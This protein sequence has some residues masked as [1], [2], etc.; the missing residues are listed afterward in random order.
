MTPQNG[1]LET[2]APADADACW[3]AVLARD[4]SCD[5]R[6]VCAVRTTGIYCRPS[7]P[8]G[9]PRREN[10]V[11]Y[12]L[13]ELAERDGFRA[14]KR[15]HPRDATAE[16]HVET[17]R[18]ACRYIEANLEEPLTLAV[19]GGQVGLSPAHLQ[20]IFKRVAGISPRQYAD[21]CRLGRLKAGLKSRRTVTMAMFEAGYGSSSRLYERAAQQ[22]GMTPATYQRG[23]RGMQIR[24]TLAD[25][26]LGRLLLAA[27]ERGVCAVCIGDAD[28]VLE[29]NLRGEYP[30]A[31][32]ER[33]DSALRPLV[34]DM[35]EHLAGERPHLE[36][37][38][39]VQATAFQW[40]VW[41]ELQAI[42]YGETRTYQEVARALGQPSA[43]RAVARAC[44]TNP[45]AVV[46][47]CH[48]VLRTDGGLGGYRWGLQRKQKLLEQE[49]KSA[50][51]A[52]RAKRGKRSRAG[53]S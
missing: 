52:V 49:R 6:F 15:C 38:I 23:G 28:R 39:D 36:L 37:P 42:P 34:A 5:G 3:R 10:V 50:D 44:A 20:R 53:R 2:H 26:P 48:R 4:A 14:C 41:R 25:S 27:T 16:P 33:D 45:V 47:P 7:C 31:E 51:E 13:P 40:R 46:V 24:Y 11:F 22:L 8:A 30:A 1:H 19:L 43:V 17:V 12:A 21:A 29:G 18:A 35:V 32:V 9:P